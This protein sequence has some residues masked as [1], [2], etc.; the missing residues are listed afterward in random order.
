MDRC[1]LVSRCKRTGAF[2]L[3]PVST[4]GP[5]DV[6]LWEVPAGVADDALGQAVVDLL[7]VPGQA[8]AAPAGEREQQTERLWRRYGLDGPTSAYAKR[9]LMASVTQRPGRKSWVVQVL[10]YDPRHRA[11]S[12]DGQPSARVRHAAG[13]AALGNALRAALQ[14]PQ[15]RRTRPRAVGGG[16]GPGRGSS[17]GRRPVSPRN[18]GP[19]TSW[20]SSS[21]RRSR[22]PPSP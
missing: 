10:R 5:S 3:N 11:M 14:L 22:F 13:R 7:V 1:V 21:A 15:Q 16:A 6:N 9:V 20:T 17:G 2:L 12:G 19:A 18:V 8:S 4:S